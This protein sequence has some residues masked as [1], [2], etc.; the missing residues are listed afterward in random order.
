MR[1]FGF[2]TL[3]CPG[4]DVEAVLTLAKRYGAELVQLRCAAD[5][6]VNTGIG[7]RRR[8]EVKAAFAAAGIGFWS[9][10]TYVRLSDPDLLQPLDEHVALAV[11][12]GAPGLRLFPGDVDVETGAERL[13]RAE[14][15]AEGTGVTL[16]VETHDEYLRGAQIERLL[17]GTQAV[18][19]VW[20]ILHT[21]RAGEAV[22][23]SLAALGPFLAEFQIKD[24][25]SAADRRPMAPGTGVLPLAE[26]LAALDATGS[27]VPVIFEHEAKWRADADPF[28]ESLAAA[29]A[30]VRGSG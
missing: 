26:A 14:E 17:A 15:V 23:D 18:K 13:R 5:E 19:A 4:L 27:D 25:P 30:L 2:S 1:S 8:A 16:T 29:V 20:D 12:L 10:A 11:D 7:A 28:E 3:G 21:W 22:A 6:P 24:V 9:L